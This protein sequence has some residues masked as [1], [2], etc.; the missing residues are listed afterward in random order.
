MMS[1][2]IDQVF[3]QLDTSKWDAT[4]D[5]TAEDLLERTESPEQPVTEQT[6]QSSRIAGQNVA[7]RG[8]M[9]AIQGAMKWV[10]EKIGIPV[11]DLVDNVFQ[12]NKRTPDQIAKDRAARD[13][14]L[15]EQLGQQK[16]IND[17]P[18]P[19]KHQ[20]QGIR[21]LGGVIA[22]GTTG[23]AESVLNT[24]EILGDTGKYLAN[25]GNVKEDQNPFSSKYEWASWDLGKDEA[26]AQ[27]GVG[28][29][30]QGFLEFGILM[31]GTGGFNNLPGAAT[32]FAQ[33]STT[34]GKV[35]VAAQAGAY[36]A[37]SGLAADMM[38][39][40]RGE[41]NLSNLIKEN[42]PEWYPTFLTALAVDEDDSP[43]EA[44]LKTGLEGMGIGFAADS[45][46][47]Y[48]G[49]A[50]EANRILK[51]GGTEEEA[52]QAAVTTS[53]AILDNA[54]P[55]TPRTDADAPLYA[56]PV[57]DQ[58]R[59][60]QNGMDTYKP[61][62]P[63][64][65]RSELSI[66]AQL[67]LPSNGM[68]LDAVRFT[69]LPNGTRVEWGFQNNK[70]LARSY[71]LSTDRPIY[72]VSWDINAGE[73]GLQQ[74]GRRLMTDFNRMAREEM[75]PGTILA[76]SP[77]E[78]S[79]SGISRAQARRHAAKVDGEAPSVRERLYTHAG[80]GK[81]DD[82][83]YQY[84]IVRSAPDG[85]GRWLQ[86][87]EIPE[88][89]TIADAVEDAKAAWIRTQEAIGRTGDLDQAWSR[90]PMPERQQKAM[91]YIASGTVK[92]LVN[93]EEAIA[94]A[95]EDATPVLW[96]GVNDG[97]KAFPEKSEAL[98]KLIAQS[99]QGIPH[100][101]DDVASVFPEYFT[102][103]A[104][105]VVPEFHAGVYKALDELTPD[106]GFTIN[107]FTG[108]VP[109]SGT[110]VAIDGK[111]LEAFGPN[112]VAG[113]IA[114]NK[115][116]L[117]R[118]DVYLGGWYS[119]IT[120]Q[121]V[122]E[123]S[124][125]V[126]QHDQAV[127]LGKLFD[128]EGV[129][130]MDD[131][132][133]IPTGG[134]DELKHTIGQHIDTRMGSPMESRTVDPTTSVGQ[135]MAA[136][137][138]IDGSVGSSQPTITR[139]QLRRIAR[140]TGDE[141]AQ[142][143]R[144]MVRE[145]P[146]NLRELSSVSRQSVEDV[147]NE[148]GRGIQE[149]LGAAGDVDFNKLLTQQVGGDELLTRAGIVQVRGLMQEMTSRLY[150]SS[151]NI[152]KLGDA[153]MDSFPQVQRMADDLKALMKV[154]KESANAYSRM[155]SSYKIKVPGLGIEVS[156][157]IK[158]PSPEKLAQEIKDAGKVIDEMV[159]KMASGDIKAQN[160]AFR[161]A[162]ALLLSEGD[163]SK[164]PTVW[165]YIRQ[166]AGGDALS[167]MYNS[168]LSGPKTH[169][170]NLLSNAFNTFYR[171]AAAAMGGQG[172]AAAAAFYGFGKNLQ[173]AFSMAAK[174]MK[175]GPISEGSKS[176]VKASETAQKLK[177]LQRSAEISDDVGFKAA[178]GF[179]DMLHKTAEY[180]L[181]SWPSKLLTGSD[182]FFKVMVSRMEFNSQSML[183]AIDQA[184]GMEG[185]ST[186]AIFKNLLK[187][188]F[189]TAFDP[190]TGAI[191]DDTLL[192][193]AKDVTFQTDLEG[194]AKS[195]GEFVNA[196]PPLRIFFP[197]VKTGHNIMVYAGTHVPVLNRF[198]SEYK[199]VMEGADE[200][201]KAVMKG[202]EAYGRMIVIGGGMAVATG[203]MTGNGP[204]DPAQKK[205]WL[206]NNQPRS[207]NLTK[208][209]G[210]KGEGGK[211]K[212][213]DYSRIE[214]F[215]QILSGIADVY[216]MFTTG[217]LAE[218]RAQYMM[219]YLTYA[220]AANF[221]NKSYMQG[222]V[223]LGQILTPGWQG[224]STLA[225]LPAET[226]NNFIPLSGLRRT[227]AN[228]MTP[229]RMEF[230]GQLERLA[231]TASGSLIKTGA[232]AADWLTG[233]DV[234]SISGGANALLPLAIT[235]R[236]GNVVKDGLEDIEFDSSVIL[237]S[238]GG[239]KLDA[240]QKR[241][242]ALRMAEGGGLQKSLEKII[243]DPSWREAV[244]DFKVRLRAGDPIRK[245]DQMF[246]KQVMDTIL[247]ARDYAKDSLMADPEFAGKV[248]D[249][250]QSKRYG[251]K[252][253]EQPYIDMTN[254]VNLPLK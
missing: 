214:P 52:A 120:G 12:G 96:R 188:N 20:A 200:Y 89:R 48:I 127:T 128:Q 73:E 66:S 110:V 140:A 15:A 6:P 136:R 39:A 105:E 152:M 130:R 83:G 169:E 4:K 72:E 181:F 49:G 85:R 162:N 100:T 249:A 230:N 187:E 3:G 234:P 51:A 225:S 232:K 41:G 164:M 207:F 135:Q 28:K 237:K 143:L 148:A 74:Y 217:Q 155:L 145:N 79:Y 9:D 90:I 78:D 206:M 153:S 239:I 35:G 233:E 117:S 150:E 77:A 65:E 177:V 133:Y 226:A 10:D 107:P 254:L 142:I 123:I 238:L 202:R 156:N 109:T 80:F 199:T 190:K 250:K 243:N 101:W 174:A 159:Q 131:G 253:A 151:Y 204:A 102:P 121:P 97:I 124:R 30:A 247:T 129:F 194:W 7:Q 170:I 219:G 178:V 27:T 218:D 34:L 94:K 172:Q 103:G 246:Y 212:F 68:R 38:S 122:I 132:K 53:R 70:D 104:R 45:L 180:P 46:G 91:D 81:V 114:D 215:G 22:G 144:Q 173:D 161:L 56:R 93:A 242:L 222:V 50:R 138:S 208:I 167:I 175:D 21:E 24:A 43:W 84:A 158:P 95:V 176:M 26:G 2:Y 64:I 116:L 160:E 13:Q 63:R 25:L 211:D 19:L 62:S 223:P 60:Y 23:A 149:A 221:T 118:D 228:L 29:V 213:L 154:H 229:Y 198:L 67:E 157:P 179:I 203:A 33:A 139:A 141:P 47:A 220:I 108:E 197:F 134:A 244:E 119:E 125:L 86:P 126:P 59:A 76:N 193:A 184:K 99:R 216:D 57:D 37:A 235:D 241:E 137:G 98:Q 88:G 11:E 248:M 186:D 61:D 113:F 111:S 32:K 146:I 54:T 171:P 36:G 31:A 147:V 44:M 55:F 92:P 231:Y 42:A 252:E 251:G 245:E 112:D 5:V 185:A 82:L 210:I 168:M 189:D 195:F 166:I 196:V 201:S 69:E 40:T 240:R 224:A 106:G 18:G 163:I 183:N 236:G 192:K 205:L 58:V 8:G 1:D 71:S 191:L 75:S 87:I 14:S 17:L 165:K 227:V 16:T 209:F 182:E 115:D